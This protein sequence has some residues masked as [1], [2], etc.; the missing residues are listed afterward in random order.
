M[1][2]LVDKPETQYDT[3]TIIVLKEVGIEAKSIIVSY[4]FWNSIFE[5]NISPN[6]VVIL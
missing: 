5:E 1:H 4:R 2:L 6:W 3:F